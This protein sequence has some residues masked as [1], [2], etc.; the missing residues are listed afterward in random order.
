MKRNRGSTVSSYKRLVKR[1][2]IE[3]DKY[4]S[5]LLTE[6]QKNNDSYIEQLFMESKLIKSKVLIITFY[7]IVSK[8][9]LISVKD[10]ALRKY[11]KKIPFITHFKPENISEEISD[12]VILALLDT[13]DENATAKRSN[14]H[15]LVARDM[16]MDM[17]Q[18]NVEY[19]RD[20]LSKNMSKT[21][22]LTGDVQIS[23]V[24]DE[25]G[26]SSNEETV[27]KTG[28][29]DPK[30][31]FEFIDYIKTISDEP[32][33]FGDQ[34]GSK[35]VE[36]GTGIA[37]STALATTML[38]NS[39]DVATIT[40]NNTN[41]G[42]FNTNPTTTHTESSKSGNSSRTNSSNRDVY[43]DDD[44]H[45]DDVGL[46]NNK[47]NNNQS[48]T[49]IHRSSSTG[50]MTPFSENN[51]KTN[52]CVTVEQVLAEEQQGL[53]NTNP[54]TDDVVSAPILQISNSDDDDDDDPNIPLATEADIRAN[55]TLT[56]LSQFLA[57]HENL[58]ASDD[59]D[60]SNEEKHDKASSDDDDDSDDGAEVVTKS[61]N[62][63]NRVTGSIEEYQNDNA[64]NLM[65]V[66]N[67]KIAEGAE[68][69]ENSNSENDSSDVV[70]IL[71]DD[72][73][74]DVGVTQSRSVSIDSDEDDIE[75]ISDDD[76]DDE[77]TSKK[78]K[79]HKKSKHAQKKHRKHKR[80]KQ[81]TQLSNVNLSTLFNNTNTSKQAALDAKPKITDVN[82]LPP[83]QS[84]SSNVTDMQQ[85]QLQNQQENTIKLPPPY[86]S[87]LKRKLSNEDQFATAAVVVE[88][89]SESTPEFAQPPNKRILK[90]PLEIIEEMRMARATSGNSGGA[91]AGSLSIDQQSQQQGFLGHSSLSSKINLP[92]S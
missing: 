43:D 48:S 18:V 40:Q 10:V 29:A 23:D 87:P 28:Y 55:R 61:R 30:T 45:D 17:F 8:Q 88:K 69:D 25:N 70:E 20:I 82:Q 14:P 15:L 66:I 2:F 63:D 58:E 91:A 22:T 26:Q 38:Y 47:T 35:L 21:R 78:S 54:D 68:N 76:D 36:I 9:I 31:D 1:S 64:I 71:S 11:E 85:S 52:K 59:E 6:E 57:C 53:H 41:N 90:S 89:S 92:F 67:R 46:E 44:D 79:H 51:S 12:E 60:A 86:I 19:L 56:M 37:A 80:D 42:Q 27:D 73:E 77:R 4:M 32:P 39:N 84:K 72:E 16:L 33:V 5:Q 62:S 83:F 3:G 34:T 13:V 24:N 75:T 74:D 81:T 65:D 50:N 7:K 49:I